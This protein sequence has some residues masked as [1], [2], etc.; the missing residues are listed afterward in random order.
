MADPS[1]Y[2]PPP[3]LLISILFLPGIALDHYLPISKIQ[4][5]LNCLQTSQR[6]NC[7]QEHIEPFDVKRDD[8]EAPYLG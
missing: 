6:L 5:F 4:P 3:L 7:K 1:F 2:H 8:S